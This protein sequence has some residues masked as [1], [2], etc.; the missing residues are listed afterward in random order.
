[1]VDPGLFPKE[2]A[3][4][5]KDIYQNEYIGNSAKKCEKESDIKNL[6]DLL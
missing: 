1:M 3:T 5:I 4:H 6:N 2:M